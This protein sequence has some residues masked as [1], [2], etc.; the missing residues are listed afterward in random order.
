MVL[1]LSLAAV[2]V[3]SAPPCSTNASPFFVPSAGICCLFYLPSTR[4]T[5]HTI[6]YGTRIRISIQGLPNYVVVCAAHEHLRA[7]GPVAAWCWHM[8]YRSGTPHACPFSFRCL[9]FPWSRKSHVFDCIPRPPKRP[10]ASRQQCPHGIHASIPL[11]LCGYAHG[12]AN[13]DERYV[14]KKY[15]KVKS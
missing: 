3:S 9:L 5:M 8:T 4:T 6:P 2:Y 1:S 7:H 15:R 14:K 13:A 12:E 11:C 10:L